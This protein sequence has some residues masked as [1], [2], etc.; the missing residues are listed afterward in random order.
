MK[1]VEETSIVVEICSFKAEVKTK[2][3]RGSRLS[4]VWVKDYIL[5]VLVLWTGE[6]VDSVLTRTR[7]SSGLC[8]DSALMSWSE[9]QKQHSEFVYTQW[10]WH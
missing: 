3:R 10:L 2:L 5:M 6:H 7:P 9:L 8:L 1:W 4:R